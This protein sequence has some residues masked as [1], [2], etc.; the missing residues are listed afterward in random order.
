M[1]DARNRAGWNHTSHILC[2]IANV[3]RDPKKGRA[4]KPADFN[5][6]GQSRRN[7]KRAPVSVDRFTREVMLIAARKER[8]RERLGRAAHGSS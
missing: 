8:E 3:N 6:Y 2:L 1:A 4:F 5:P 7:S